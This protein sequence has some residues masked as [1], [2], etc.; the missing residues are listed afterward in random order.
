MAKSRVKNKE[1]IMGSLNSPYRET[2]MRDF[3]LYL[4][5][6]FCI[7]NNYIKCLKFQ[8]NKPQHS[9][10]LSKKEETITHAKLDTLIFF[11]KIRPVLRHL[12][13]T[14]EI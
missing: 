9:L 1:P 2:G 3:G 6:A 10:M 13:R 4:W 14:D 8:Q 12:R 7:K 11:A 5:W